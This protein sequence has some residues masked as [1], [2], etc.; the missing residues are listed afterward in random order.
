MPD[1]PPCKAK[2]R[3]ELR[4]RRQDLSP[5]SQLAAAAATAR[6]I[7]GVPGWSGARRIALYLAN[8]GEVATTPVA[9]LCRTTGKQLFLPV[10]DEQ[11]V[12]EFA[13]WIDGAELIANRFGIP[14]PPP[15]SLRCDAS[16]L[17]IIL[18]PLVAWDRLGGRL[19]MGGGFYD[20]TLAGVKGPLLVG[21]AHEVQEVPQ[22][23][24]DDW[25]ILLDFVVTESALYTCQG[26]N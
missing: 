1:R 2:L 16:E 24:R 4:R 10:I 21:L 8:D 15:H 19:G 7:T 23:P 14:E 6:H 25:D 9:E 20:R 11:N 5:S 17:N 3:K 22:V 26:K 13:E 12:L 18:M